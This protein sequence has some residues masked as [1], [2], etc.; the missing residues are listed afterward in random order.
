MEK[1]K[2]QVHNKGGIYI[3]Y[4]GILKKIVEKAKSDKKTIILPEA[5]DERILN[6]AN[7]VTKDEIANIVL[8]G[9]TDEII[10][11][12]KRKNIDLDE[13]IK[14]INPLEYKQIEQYVNKFYELR[15]NKGITL[16]DAREILKNDAYFATM[17]VYMDQADG[18]VSGAC[19]TT[20]DTLRPALQIIKQKDNL[21]CVSSFF[22]METN[23]KELGENGV[24][25]FSDCGLMIDPTSNELQ[26]IS[27][28]SVDSFRN[29]VGGIPK[30]AFLSYSSFGSSDDYK[31]LEA[32]NELK[33]KEVN[34]DF[35]GE[36][37]LDTAICK[38]VAK[39][40]APNS[41]V[42][43]CANI[44]IFPNLESGNIGYKIAQRFGNMTALGPITQGIKKPVNDLSRGCSV[45]DIVGVIAI[46]CVQAM[47]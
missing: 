15:K 25:I 36:M 33:K 4:K 31:V 18:M 13:R 12:A 17:M 41:K 1:Y 14:I 44:L 9:N 40:K 34:Y 24:Y 26:D 20:P 47:N 43:G 10:E 28:C 3:Y 5:L 11:N 37:Q 23:K 27:N 29:L 30:V 19:N 42:A 2:K 16:K 8:I 38:D 39:K 45:E 21:S 35:D 32:V 7:I 46:T 22:I 6:A